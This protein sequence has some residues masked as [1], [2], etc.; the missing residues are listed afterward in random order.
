MNLPSWLSKA[1]FYQIY[2]PSFYDSNDDGIGDIP[3]IMEKLDYIKSLGCNAVWLNPCFLSPFNDG[4]YDISDF[5]QVAPRYGTNNDLKCLFEKAH[6]L[7]M[8]ICLD[9]VPC[10][11]S[12]E[13][14]WFREST[15]SEENSYTNRYIWTD[16]VWKD[17]NTEM[18]TIN[19]FG[20]RDGRYMA[21]FFYCQPSLNYGFAKSKYNWQLPIHHPDSIATKEELKKIMN[22]W[23]DMGADGFRVDMASAII[24]NDKG[25]Q[26]TTRFW[27]DIRASLSEKYPEMVLISEWGVPKA[28]IKAGFH[29]DFML[30]FNGSAY[31]S[32]FRQEVVR[33]CFGVGTEHG[34]SVFDIEG[35][36]DISVFKDSFM[37]H[38]RSIGKKGYIAIP[39]SSHDITRLNVQRSIAELKVAMAFLITQPGIPFIYY[40][41]EI[42]MRYIH[43]LSSKEGG[44]GR[45][46]SRTPMQWSNKKNKGFSN[47]SSCELYLPIDR[48]K[49]APTVTA[50][51]RN[52]DSLLNTVKQLIALRNGSDALSADG[53][54]TPLYVEKN[55]YPIVYMRNK[56]D[57]KFIVV[58]NPT[59][60]ETTAS[61][62]LPKRCDVFSVLGEGADMK[63]LDKKVTLKMLPVSYEIFKVEYF[64]SNNI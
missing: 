29:I 14:E 3:G 52:K 54:F 50:S 53:G 12:I 24:K 25:W 19:G 10:H 1:V 62:N 44:Y 8:R 63:I 48:E 46:G 35:K 39:S 5:Y 26:Q 9:L 36:G 55:K 22:F 23:L 33:D 49:A 59:Q 38:Y 43:G 15:K 58:L 45:T 6:K 27:R 61:F 20:N 31:T 41:D 51:L 16:N 18:A 30:H 34:N 2:P 7:D 47:A 56:G 17:Y 32:L 37:D 11:T 4:G 40:G 21:S 28:A 57:E 13:H 60:K 42:G 64:N